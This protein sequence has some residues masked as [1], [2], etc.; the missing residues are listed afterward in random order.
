MEKISI[1]IPLSIAIEIATYGDNGKVSK[2]AQLSIEKELN[3]LGYQKQL[4][5]ER[6]NKTKRLFESLK[7]T[8]GSDAMNKL[9]DAIKIGKDAITIS[10][11]MNDKN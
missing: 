4:T 8:L 2:I 5:E 11:R 3:R 1:N 9:D 6:K 10:K 7:K